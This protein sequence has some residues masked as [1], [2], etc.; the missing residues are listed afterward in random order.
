M[1][2]IA[3][4]LQPTDDDEP[5]FLLRKLLTEKFNE[6]SDLSNADGNSL[7]EFACFESLERAYDHLHAWD[8]TGPHDL[9][10]PLYLYKAELSSVVLEVPDDFN[11]TDKLENMVTGIYLLYPGLCDIA[12]SQEIDDIE[13]RMKALHTELER[14][15]EDKRDT[16]HID[17]EYER[18]INQHDELTTRLKAFLLRP[19]KEYPGPQKREEKIVQHAVAPP[20]TSPLLERQQ[21]GPAQGGLY[22]PA[23]RRISRKVTVTTVTVQIEEEELDQGEVRS[24]GLKR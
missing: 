22:A 18:V 15:D 2:Y 24:S 14:A 13:A 3:I 19:F 11:R 7:Y 17:A 10:T 1:K 5:V 12:L 16:Q 23:P 6:L 8:V 21:V 4:V 20:L 9:P